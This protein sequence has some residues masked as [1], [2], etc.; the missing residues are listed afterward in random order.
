MCHRSVHDFS[1]LNDECVTQFF[2][3]T[4]PFIGGLC[5]RVL[6]SAHPLKGQNKYSTDTENGMAYQPPSLGLAMST[7]FQRLSTTSV[8]G[9]ISGTALLSFLPAPQIRWIDESASLRGIED[10]QGGEGL[11]MKE[12][13]TI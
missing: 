7:I 13:E 11:S 3:S 1:P 4:I 2:D 8:E 6:R 12:E 5:V 9:G 10:G